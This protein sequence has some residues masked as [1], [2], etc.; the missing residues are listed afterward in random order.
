MFERTHLRLYVDVFDFSRAIYGAVM[1]AHP[2]GFCL[3]QLSI[4]GLTC[5]ASEQMCMSTWMEIGNK[6]FKNTFIFKKLLLNLIC[7]T[8]YVLVTSISAY[9]KRTALKT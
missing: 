5:S 8:K 1:T 3:V 2:V 7:G 4:N 9:T 6:S